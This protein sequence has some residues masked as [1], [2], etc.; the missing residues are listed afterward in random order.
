MGVDND[1]NGVVQVRFRGDHTGPRYAGGDV[2]LAAPAQHIA[3]GW[4]SLLEVSSVRV[5]APGWTLPLIPEEGFRGC[6][7]RT[8]DGGVDTCRAL[9]G[10][11]LVAFLPEL[12]V[13][14]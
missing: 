10:T 12:L 13:R 9:L 3:E 4:A 11:P 8:G 6:P 2:E 1:A 5:D 7:V 14:P